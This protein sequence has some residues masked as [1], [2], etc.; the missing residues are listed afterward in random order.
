MQHSMDGAL[1]RSA[2]KAHRCQ[3]A[4]HCIRPV[5]SA[6]RSVLY[7]GSVPEGTGPAWHPISAKGCAL[8]EINVESG[9][10]QQGFCG[11]VLVRSTNDW[12]ILAR[13]QSSDLTQPGSH[14][15]SHVLLGRGHT[16][17]ISAAAVMGGKAYQTFNNVHE[18]VC[19]ACGGSSRSTGRHFSGLACRGQ[20]LIGHIFGIGV[21]SER[22]RRLVNLLQKLPKKR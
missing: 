4:K 12:D 1:E 20:H 8:R 21:R 10:L 3:T 18:C 16:K 19:H 17:L 15:S 14:L 7:S 6:V 2:T 9:N 22:G 13:V 11:A 5:H